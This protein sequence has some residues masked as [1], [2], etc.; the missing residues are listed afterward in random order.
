MRACLSTVLLVI[1]C[2]GR[3]VVDD[4]GTGGA[5]NGTGS[6]GTGPSSGS[7]ASTV[8]SSTS[9][10]PIC[11]RIA[12]CTECVTSCAADGPCAA[13]YAAASSNSDATAFWA[14]F[15]GAQCG[16][17]PDWLACTNMCAAQHRSGHADLLAYYRCIECE[18]C[19]SCVE[20]GWTQYYG[21]R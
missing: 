11:T 1:S 4:G 10:M 8:S 21:C 19:P 16:S 15:D 18:H 9:G 13:L 7:R 3:V 12:D 2:G 20:S 14:C 6:G 17:A 5:G